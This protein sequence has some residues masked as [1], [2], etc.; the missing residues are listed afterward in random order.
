MG[1]ER[2]VFQKLSHLVNQRTVI[3]TIGNTL[4]GDD[5]AGPSVFEKLKGKVSVELVDT[6]TVPENYIGVIIQKEPKNLIVIDA[7]EFDSSPGDIRIFE[8]EQVNNVV[9]STHSLSPHLFVEMIR[10]E[11]EVDVYFI[12]IQP[13]QTKM[14]Q[15]LSA[16]VSEAVD[17]LAKMLIE[18]F[19]R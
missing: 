17:R 10:A 6:G 1:I 2:Q 7:M 9:L 15:P 5:G 4:K 3:V 19:A 14:G 8:A 13:A 18:V 16:P 11:L 12:G